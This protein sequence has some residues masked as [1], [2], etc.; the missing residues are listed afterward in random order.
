VPNR[1]GTHL[2]IQSVICAAVA[3]TFCAS[4]LGQSN[5]PAGFENNVPGGQ[6][7]EA[8]TRASEAE[9]RRVSSAHPDLEKNGDSHTIGAGETLVL[10]ELEG[11]GAITHL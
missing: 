11:P 9:T 7:F 8:L 3:S 2:I 1:I 10:A 6:L 4:V 5:K